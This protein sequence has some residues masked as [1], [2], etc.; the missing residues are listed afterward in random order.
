MPLYI[1]LCNKFTSAY[2][3][4]LSKVCVVYWLLITD[5]HVLPGCRLRSNQ[6]G[7]HS[8]CIEDL[9]HSWISATG[10][11]YY[12]PCVNHPWGKKV[13]DCKSVAKACPLLKDCID[14]MNLSY[15]PKLKYTF[16]VFQKLFLELDV[17][18]M[19]MSPKVQSLHNNLLSWV[20]LCKFQSK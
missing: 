14:A 20:F 6:R 12:C 7:L 16:K 18:K 17:L 1:V 11:L 5:S 2:L 8:L 15:P 13:L 19:K 9:Y 4:I 3:G 10:R